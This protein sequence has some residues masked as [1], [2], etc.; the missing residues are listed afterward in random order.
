MAN[1]RIDA[2]KAKQKKQKI[3]AAVLGVVF[4]GVLGFQGPRVWKQLHPA[5]TQARP[6][7]NETTST[8]ERV[9]SWPKATSVR[10]PP[11]RSSLTA[12]SVACGV[13]VCR[14]MTPSWTVT[15]VPRCGGALASLPQQLAQTATSIVRRTAGPLGESRGRLS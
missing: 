14:S 7:Y 9:P 12:V 11:D 2:L 8:T 4:I 10:G 5:T 13:S 6:S 15:L 1:R 3:I